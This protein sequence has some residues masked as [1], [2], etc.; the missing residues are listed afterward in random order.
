MAGYNSEKE[1]EALIEEKE[2]EVLERFGEN[3]C[4]VNENS[5]QDADEL[6]KIETYKIIQK[7]LRSSWL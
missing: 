5:N 1:F 4:C 3:D 2:C 7:H 6:A